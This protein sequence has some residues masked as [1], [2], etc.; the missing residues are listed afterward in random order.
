MER[1]FQA[2][3]MEYAQRSE[4]WLAN[5]LVTLGSQVPF[6]KKKYTDKGQQAI[7]FHHR[8]SQEDVSRGTRLKELEKGKC[9]KVKA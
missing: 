9:R 2:F 4:D 1:K 8:D 7:E 5:A 3:G 6:E